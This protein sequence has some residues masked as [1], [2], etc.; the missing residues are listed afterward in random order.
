MS[1][2]MP[3]LVAVQVAGCAPV[4]RAIGSGAEAI[5]PWENAHTVASGLRV[6]APFA[7]RLILRSVRESGGTAVS[8]GEEEMLDAT[9]DLAELEGCFA[10][11]EGGATLA[12]LR[13]LRASG[14][15]AA[16]HRVVIFNTGSGLKYPEAWRRVLE[17]R[18]A[19]ARTR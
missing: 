8:V 6:P 4:V 13:H 11:P 18:S 3:R 1:G 14:E 17:R 5:A 16:R 2:P 12:A 7:E 10:C 15:I 19:A 9:G